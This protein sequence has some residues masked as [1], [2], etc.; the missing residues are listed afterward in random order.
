MIGA[1]RLALRRAEYRT[2]KFQRRGGLCNN[3]SLGVGWGEEGRFC[4]SGRCSGAALYLLGPH[5]A[6][7]ITVFMSRDT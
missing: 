2:G 6:V 4:H 5:Q 1:E 3:M 7:P